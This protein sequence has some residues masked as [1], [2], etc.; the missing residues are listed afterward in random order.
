MHGRAQGWGSFWPTQ[1]FCP[2]GGVRPLYIWQ[3]YN[4]REGLQPR[5]GKSVTV[6]ILDMYD[7]EGTLGQD[8]ALDSYLTSRVLCK[9]LEAHP[10]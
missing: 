4:W 2:S 10:R 7:K 3:L 5:K 8:L 1:G 6:L 9:H